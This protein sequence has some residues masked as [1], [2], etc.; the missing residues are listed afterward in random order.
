MTNSEKLD[1]GVENLIQNAHL[2]IVSSAFS[3]NFALFFRFVESVAYL[4]ISTCMFG[5]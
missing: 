2:L 1:N 3:S 5:A 4:L